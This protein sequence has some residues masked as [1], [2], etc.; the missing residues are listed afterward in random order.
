MSAGHKAPEAHEASDWLM[1]GALTLMWGS[2]FLF[3][4]L[5][6]A[7]LGFERVVTARLALAAIILVPLAV[8]LRRPWPSGVKRWLF[9]GL[10]AV[11]GN[12]LPFSL[13]TWG[14]R[15]IASGL[16]GILMAVMPLAT[17]GLAH[18]FVPGETLTRGRIWGFLLGF[19]GVL[20]LIGPEALLAIGGDRG[21]LLPMLA[22]LAGALCY[23]VSA[24]LSRLRPASDAVSTAAAVTTLAAIL[25]L[26][27]S[28]GSVLQGAS[29]LVLTPS[30]IGAVL[31]L[32]LFSTAA[33]MIV[34]F[35]LIQR[36]GPSFTS[37]LN[38]L[39]PL[40]AVAIG[41]LF[42]G[43]EPTLGHLGGLSLILGGVLLARR[44]GRSIRRALSEQVSSTASEG[45]REGRH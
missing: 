10:I 5:A 14:Q 8:A 4:K 22:V 9:F 20:L 32:G 12:L 23:G 27:A 35:R 33:A 30:V 38:Y 43:E 13:I 15:A 25:S 41:I 40:W 39:I 37:Q 36:A 31:F 24:I 2:S 3:T 11:I 45:R 29:A 16:A 19:T 26:P 28:L 17:L 21:P 34:Y 42:L 18:L 1:L 7:G 6:V 44:A